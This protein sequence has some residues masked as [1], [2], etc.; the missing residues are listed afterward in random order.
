MRPDFAAIAREQRDLSRLVDGWEAPQIIPAEWV[1]F[2]RDASGAA[3]YQNARRGLGAILSC[4]IENDGRTWLHL[5]V[6]HRIRVP[7]WK[8]LVD[9]KVVF[10]GDREAYQVIPPKARY[11]NIDSRV[12]HLWALRD[13]D[14]SVLP[15]FTRGTRSI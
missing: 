12:L 4:S 9:A 3:R 10:L 7:K 5:S 13:K 2:D 1:E 8:E 15:D 11:V 6:S 14:A